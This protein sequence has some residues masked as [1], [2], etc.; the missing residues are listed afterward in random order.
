M[1]NTKKM[2]KIKKTIG[3]FIT[4]LFLLSGS[5]TLVS[6]PAL[7]A[8]PEQAAPERAVPERILSIAPAGTEILFELGLGGRIIGVTRYCTW[9]PEART[10]FNLGGMLHVSIETVMGLRPDLV[11]V[12]NMNI[13]IGERLEALGFRVVAV[14]QDSFEEICASI[15]RVGRESGVEETAEL[16][17]AELRNLVREKTLPMG[18]EP[19][20]VLVVVG[21]D[22]SENLRR[23]YIAGQMAFYND[24]LT[25][26]GAVNAYGHNVPYAH[27]TLEGLLR[28]DP[29]VIIELVGG[30]GTTN[31][32]ASA[33][34]EAES[35]VRAAREGRVFL[36]EGDFAFRPGPRYPEILGAFI[37]AIHGAARE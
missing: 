37:E 31:P 24:L 2:K 27:I 9:P 20:R 13:Q 33:W 16:R 21:R 30:H 7:A 32:A 14:N 3:V 34:G 28:L 1:G 26:A 5:V 36:I 35:G 15:L 10:I 11:L 22:P 17:V 4:L 19:P 12:S 18:A 8:V 23:L 25:K 29:D 6:H